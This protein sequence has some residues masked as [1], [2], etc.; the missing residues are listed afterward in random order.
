LSATFDRY[1]HRKPAQTGFVF[2][3]GMIEAN[4]IEPAIRR[5]GRLLS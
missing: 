2:G 4:D 3:L 5:L 1:A